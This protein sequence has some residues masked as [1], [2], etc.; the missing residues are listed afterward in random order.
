MAPKRIDQEEVEKY[1][2]IFSSLANGG[3]LL[4]G[5]QVAPVLKNSNLRDDQ[6][7]RV[8]DLADVDNDGK[9]DFEEFC[10]AMRLIFD[11]ING[12]SYAR[13]TA[14]HKSLH[15]CNDVQERHANHY[16]AGIVRR[17]HHTP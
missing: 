6:L 8:W 7:E 2:E 9:L 5:E 17:P 14:A 10:V 16:V 4:S 3:S 11:L 15:C 12:V 1:W 13:L